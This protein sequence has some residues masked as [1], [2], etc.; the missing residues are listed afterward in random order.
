MYVA[1]GIFKFWHPSDENIVLKYFFVNV[2]DFVIMICLYS[3]FSM[4]MFRYCQTVDN[5]FG[6]FLSNRRVIV[7]H[8]AMVF[9]LTC[10]IILPTNNVQESEFEEWK[11]FM[12]QN[13]T[14]LYASIENGMIY[15]VRVCDIDHMFFQKGP[16]FFQCIPVLA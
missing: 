7:F 2:I 14:T 1:S 4:F 16:S 6:E 3:A 5:R 11:N 15:G 8:M 12:I 9:V 13:D 10:V